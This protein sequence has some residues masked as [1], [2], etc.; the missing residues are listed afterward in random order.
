MIWCLGENN[1]R[2]FVRGEDRCLESMMSI[3]DIDNNIL[4]SG[5]GLLG[6]YQDKYEKWELYQEINSILVGTKPKIIA[7]TVLHVT[8]AIINIWKI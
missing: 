1:K 2:P 6:V 4:N 7:E 5:A 3:H 8:H